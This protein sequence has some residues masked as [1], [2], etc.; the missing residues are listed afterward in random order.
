M[1]KTL[2]TV[3]LDVLEELKGLEPIFHRQE[4]G[5][6]RSDFEKMTTPDF[7]EIGASGRRYTREYVLDV[8]DKRAQHP[9]GDVWKTSEFR[10]QELAQDLYLLTYAL[11]QES[12]RRAGHLHLC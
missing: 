8:L 4:F 2:T 3:D 7:W 10:C 5:V 1:K 6:T 12:V 11:E 9:A